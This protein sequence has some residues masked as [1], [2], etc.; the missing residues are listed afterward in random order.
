MDVQPQV[1][2]DTPAILVESIWW[3]ARTD[4]LVWVDIA[5]GTLHRGPLDGAVDGSDD[6]VTELPPPLSAV[7]PRVGSGY[8][9][10]LGDRIVTLDE[11]GLIAETV[12]RID[13]AHAGMRSNEAKVD[14]FGRFL[15]GS[16]NTTTGDPDAALYLLDDTGLRS[17][18]GGFGVANGFEWSD[19]GRTVYLTDTAVKTVYRAAYGEDG[20]LGP[21][22]A[23][24]V[25]YDSD[26]LALDTEGRFWN[27]VSGAGTVLRWGPDGAVEDRLTVPVSGVTSVAFGG[28]ELSTLFVGTSRDGLSEDE[29]ERAPL[30]GAI[31]RFDGLATGRP[32]NTY[33]RRSSS[34]AAPAGTPT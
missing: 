17:L 26:G 22:E 12:A 21:L 3:D 9:A 18:L 11:D 28:P 32:V 14:P 7:Q 5:A 20:R 10:A 34:A 4:E 24:L 13:H 31:F 33:G 27:G 25:D 16:M 8:I 19:D 1:F 30:S 15:V 2:R 29:L 23:F 6:R